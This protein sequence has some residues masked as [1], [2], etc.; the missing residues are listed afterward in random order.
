M[1]QLLGADGMR[2]TTG[3]L[4]ADSNQRADTAAGVR[5]VSS[6]QVG[7]QQDLAPDSGSQLTTA[8]AVAAAN[9]LGQRGP[10]R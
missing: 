2:L 10:H 7:P 3:Q 8:G 5:K 6:L 9:H 1:F 4:G